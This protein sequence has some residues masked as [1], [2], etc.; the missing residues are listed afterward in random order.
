MVKAKSIILIF[1]ALIMLW[2]ALLITD[3]GEVVMENEPVFCVTDDGVL[4]RGAGY[5]FEVYPH[6]VTGK[7]E[8]CFYL[9]GCPVESTFTND[10][11]LNQ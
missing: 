9:F 1:L 3:Y 4:Y 8:Y 5:S 2:A 6:L 11:V 10:A 7:R